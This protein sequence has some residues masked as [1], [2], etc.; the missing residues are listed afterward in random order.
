[1]S[2]LIQSWKQIS[3]PPPPPSPLSFPH[4]HLHSAARLTV[5]LP[6]KNSPMAELS[7]NHAKKKEK[8]ITQVYA[9]KGHNPASMP[10]WSIKAEAGIR[11]A[12]SGQW[13]LSYTWPRLPYIMR[14]QCSILNVIPGRRSKG[15]QQAGWLFALRSQSLF[16]V[17][18]PPSPWLLLQKRQD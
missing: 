12:R 10:P 18:L 17:S 16:S 7:F 9:A 3:I 8:K 2:V 1:M 14:D 13:S 15:W 11:V 6:R 5:I 4:R